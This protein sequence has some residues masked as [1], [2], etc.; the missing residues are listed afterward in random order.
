MAESSPLTPTER[1]KQRNEAATELVKALLIVNGG[2]AVAL[3][4]FLQAI[5]VSAHGLAKPIV[6]G[7][8]FF[9]IGAFAAAAFHLLRHEASYEHQFGKGSLKRLYDFGYRAAAVIS[10]L[11]FLG[12]ILEVIRGVWDVL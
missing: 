5:W 3:L 9:A 1:T 6:L 11:A 10:L 12:G 4:A 2:G 7:I 8:A